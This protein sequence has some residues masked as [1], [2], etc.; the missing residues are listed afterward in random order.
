MYPKNKFFPLNMVI[1]GTTD[2]PMSFLYLNDA[3][4]EIP[5]G[6]HVGA[7]G[8]ERRH[9]MHEGVDL[10]C[11]ET[12]PVYAIE[13]G[14]I[15]MMRAFTGKNANC[16]WWEDTDAIYIKGESGVICYGEIKIDNSL[17]L[18]DHIDAGEL[19]GEVRKVLKTDKGRPMS[20]LHIE[21]YKTPI[22]REI[23]WELGQPQPENL[24]D[25]TQLLI[26][27]AKNSCEY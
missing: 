6:S 5:I 1:S 24:L 13:D 14:E 15:I 10:Y 12:T 26:E 11:P 2:N 17:I 27:G 16:P 4:V 20:M 22:T 23:S 18:G 25:P 3:E 19:I 8:V 7:F 9:D 21:L